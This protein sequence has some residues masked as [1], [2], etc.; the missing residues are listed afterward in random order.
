M[1]LLLRVLLGTAVYALIVV[2]AAPFPSAAG[3]MLVFPTLNGLAFVFSERERVLGMARSMLWMP[4]VNGALCA[5]YMLSFLGLARFV[6]AAV[7]AFALTALVVV[8]FV[9]AARHP[10]LRAGIRAD[11]QRAFAVAATVVGLALAAAAVLLIGREPADAARLAP[12]ALG[13]AFSWDFAGEIL[14]RNAG[15][16][17]L[18]ALGLAAFLV[19]VR[20]LPLTDGARGVLAGLPFVPFAGLLSVSADAAL[21]LDARFAILRHMAASIWL[22]PAIA[23][24]FIYGFPRVLAALKPG[25]ARAIPA[26]LAAWALCGMAIAA[27]ARLVS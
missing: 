20:A 12:A 3:L 17:V 7:L 21:D 2:L 19:A 14:V 18:F 27:V 13:T 26:L 15:K 11:R 9:A 1:T 5:A 10:R 24:W 23:I 4:V 25:G 8:L 16:I 22:G 6:P